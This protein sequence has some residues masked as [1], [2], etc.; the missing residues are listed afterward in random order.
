ML[1]VSRHTG[2]AVDVISSLR[3]LARLQA[4]L[5]DP[6][7]AFVML[8]E[9]RQLANEECRAGL[10]WLLAQIA[11]VAEQ[12]GERDRAVVLGSHAF[13]EFEKVRDRDGRLDVM[14]L[15]KYLFFKCGNR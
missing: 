14:R 13:V 5:D 11:E 9:A 4:R 8:C 10:G 15:L 7:R 3:R 6:S 1:Q 12:A 2:R